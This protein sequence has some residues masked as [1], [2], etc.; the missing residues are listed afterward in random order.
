MFEKISENDGDELE[1]KKKIS[2]NDGGELEI[3]KKVEENI[4]KIYFPIKNIELQEE[5]K[6]EKNITT[7]SIYLKVLLYRCFLTIKFIGFYKQEIRE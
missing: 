6:Q 3:K 7:A 5:I 4:P 2:E 1:K